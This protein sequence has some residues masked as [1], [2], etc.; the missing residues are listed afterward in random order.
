MDRYAFDHWSVLRLI[1]GVLAVAGFALTLV[2]PLRELP[3]HL[4]QD[5]AGGVIEA[6]SWTPLPAGLRAGDR[7][8]YGQQTLL[9]RAVLI[10]E[11][12]PE[13]RTYNLR[14]QRAGSVLT[15]AVH[16]VVQSPSAESRRLGWATWAVDAML[17]ALGLLT[18]WRGRDW[19]AW[20]LA[21]F[22]LS[23]TF[24]NFT[25]VLPMPPFWNLVLLMVGWWLGGPMAFLGL[26]LTANT[27]VGWRPR[28]LH[29]PV[30]AYL[31]VLLS[32]FALEAGSMLASFMFAV[33]KIPVL[34]QVLTIAAGLAGLAVPLWVLLRGYVH[35][36]AE[37][38]LRIRWILSCTSL[39]LPIMLIQLALENT[40]IQQSPALM[41]LRWAGTAMII[42]V[43]GIYTYVVLRQRLVEVRVV[44]NRALV[45]A[46]LMGMV[47]GLFALMESLIERSAIGESASLA[48][49][50]GV[51]LAL[52]I[53]FHQLHRH[54]EALVDRV[55]FHREHRARAALSDFV[56][57]AGFIESPQT[58]IA[59][60]VEAFVCDAGVTSAALYEVRDIEFECSGRDGADSAFPDRLDQDD[61]ALVRLRATLEPLD[62]HDVGSALGA[63][64]LALPLA[65]RGHLFGVLVCGPRLAGRHAQAD[66]ERLGHAAHEIG[67]SLF[68]LRAR[69]RESLIEALARGVLSPAQA[70]LQARELAGV[71]AP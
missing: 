30:I 35:A 34:L 6:R 12:V 69:A 28:L 3:F 60:A 62:L 48:L 50:I 13:N 54:V 5:A 40:A 16:S 21:M 18:L 71:S 49:E 43:L 4:R 57:D 46:L 53:L 70:T 64:G 36:T 65:L 66:I 1:I 11:N 47:V 56:R 59:R 63:D 52:G 45:F 58:L 37:A 8:V 27:L 9:M 23:F 10:R 42:I 38:R 14:V 2:I 31:L 67:A 19:A 25:T 7:V 33:S 15:V 29:G 51:P 44:V 55:F 26:Y 24:L 68:A 39:L 20:G 61:R 41:W 32:L 22:T 17:L